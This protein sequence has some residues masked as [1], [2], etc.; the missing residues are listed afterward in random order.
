MPRNGCRYSNHDVADLAWVIGSCPL[1][2]GEAS[3]VYTLPD[4]DWYSQ[5]LNG[6]E[7]LLSALEINSS[8]LDNFLHE[9]PQKLLGK[10][11]ENL[12]EFWL[13]NN[14]E[15]EYLFSNVQL[16][17]GSATL[18]EIDFLCRERISG[19]C[20]HIETAC[21]YYL[22][23]SNSKTWASWVGPNGTDNLNTKMKKLE[24]QFLIFEKEAGRKFLER[25]SLEQPR[26]LLFLK[27]YFFLHFSLIG[28]HCSPK[29]AHPHHNGGWYLFLREIENLAGDIHQWVVPPSELWFAGYCR[30][31]E[32]VEVFN[33]R[34]LVAT[35]RNVFTETK[36]APLIIQVENRDGRLVER[37]RGFIV[38]DQWPQ[39][40]G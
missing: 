33:G 37:S 2:R 9:H 28:K 4:E 24:K 3:S 17:T 15:F 23:A 11:F 35:I 13:K 21:K 39:P 34:Q 19:D 40:A 18:G 20:V 12:V 8:S 32:E 10:R 30:S 16:K 6:A 7:G 25:N 36:K 31:A 14:D 5:K 22:A 29:S 27:G 1:L 26:R 38:H